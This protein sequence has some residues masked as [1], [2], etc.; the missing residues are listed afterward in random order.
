ML[1][2]RRTCQNCKPR[3]RTALKQ[4]I[5]ITHEYSTTTAVTADF[6]KNGTR[7][8]RSFDTEVEANAWEAEEKDV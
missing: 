7:H 1:T 3:H 4:D 2:T 6:M 5:D 8:R